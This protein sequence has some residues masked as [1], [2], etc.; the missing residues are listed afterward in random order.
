MMEM[1]P[2]GIISMILL[3]VM[4]LLFLFSC[5]KKCIRRGNGGGIK[6]ALYDSNNNPI[7]PAIAEQ[8]KFYYFKPNGIADT[9]S[10]PYPPENKVV[11]S[12][13]MRISTVDISFGI[14][15]QGITTATL[16]GEV[17]DGYL[18]LLFPDGITD[19]MKVQLRNVQGCDLYHN[20][21]Y[22]D[23]LLYNGQQAEFTYKRKIGSIEEG[24]N[25]FKAYIH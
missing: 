22:I 20:N 15:F 25:A 23:G 3:A 2:K 1:V 17:K 7:T 16:E 4:S 24:L 14:L 11:S 10:I 5:K 18:Y 8:I 13:Y 19:S 6:L 12:G 21:Y 9:F